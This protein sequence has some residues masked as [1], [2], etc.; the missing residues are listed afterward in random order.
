AAGNA[1]LKT[2]SLRDVAALAGY[3]H[4]A[5]G[6]R[7]VLVALINHPNAGAG[8]PVLDALLEWTQRDP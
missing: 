8:R 5:S 4:G 6:R 7:Y 2:G 3:V 1:H